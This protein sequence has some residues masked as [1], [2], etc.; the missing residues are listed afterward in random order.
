MKRIL[1]ALISLFF[2]TLSG[3]VSIE[4]MD[5]PFWYTGMKNRELQI[6]FYGEAISTSQFSMK[7]YDGVRI[8]E[9]CTLENPNYLIVYLDIAPDANPGKLN[10][11]FRNGRKSIS[12]DFELKERNSKEGAMGF[13]SKD[14]LYLIMPDRFANGNPDMMFLTDIR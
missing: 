14:V 7:D 11:E 6:M 8:K 4:R 1:F 3:A 13:S 10:F 12:K 5:P 2:C 9:V